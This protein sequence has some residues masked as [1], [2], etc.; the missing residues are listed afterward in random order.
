MKIMNDTYLITMLS[1]N[2]DEFKLNYYIIILAILALILHTFYWLQVIIYP[3]LHS[4]SN[5]HWEIEETVSES[6]I[7]PERE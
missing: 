6:G 4:L 1:W 3:I 5:S 2:N 7:T